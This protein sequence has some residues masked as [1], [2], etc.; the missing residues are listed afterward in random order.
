[1]PTSESKWGDDEYYYFL[2]EGWEQGYSTA[3]LLTHATRD[4]SFQLLKNAGRFPDDLDL[5]EFEGTGQIVFSVLK[6]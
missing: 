5:V 3:V 4:D 1:M 6:G 2:A